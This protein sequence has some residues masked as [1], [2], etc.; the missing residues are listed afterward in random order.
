MITVSSSFGE[1]KKKSV[2]EEMQVTVCVA[3]LVDAG[4]RKKCQVQYICM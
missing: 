1:I 3:S 4:V 2:K